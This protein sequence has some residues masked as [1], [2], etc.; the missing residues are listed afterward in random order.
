MYSLSQD[1]FG[2]L[3]AVSL[4]FQEIWSYGWFFCFFVF[5]G[6]LSGFFFG[7]WWP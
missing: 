3:K 5:F 4:I 2:V 6:F 7:P 1:M